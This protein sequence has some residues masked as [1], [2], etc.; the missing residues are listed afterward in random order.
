MTIGLKTSTKTMGKVFSI[1]YL[2]IKTEVIYIISQFSLISGIKLVDGKSIGGKG[3]LTLQRI[4][5]FQ[6]THYL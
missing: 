6:V 4:D 3:R 2:L 1:L 5:Y